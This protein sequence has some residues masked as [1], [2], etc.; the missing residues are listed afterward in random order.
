[1]WIAAIGIDRY[2]NQAWRLNN[3]VSDARGVLNAFE[4]LGF[5]E[6]ST[7][8][9]DQATN[10][11]LSCLVTD[12]LMTLNANDSL[13]VFFAGHGC[14][15]SR[16]PQDGPSMRRGYLLPVDAS[17][18]HVTWQRLDHWLSDIAHLPPRHI[19]VIL[20]S[21]H[22][23]VAL[24]HDTRWRGD[25]PKL[26][27]ADEPLRARRSRRVITSAQDNQSAIDD[28]PIRGHSLF[29]GC[30]I[31]ALLGGIAKRSREPFVTGA[32]LGDY[33][34]AEVSKRARHQ[35]TP[36]IG[37][38]EGDYGGQLFINLGKSVRRSQRSPTG[39]GA[40]PPSQSPASPS[41]DGPP[42][43]TWSPA[44]SGA[45]G[46]ALSVPPATASDAP[47]YP[48]P[49]RLAH[50]EHRATS[51]P[52]RTEGWTLD[53]ALAAALDR[54]GAERA[55]G[56]HVLSL[57]VGDAMVAQIAWATWAAGHG[58]LTLRTQA[59]SFH[60]AIADLL[61]QMP[62]LRC[63]T[64]ARKRLAAAARIDVQA[65]DAALD[66]R[67]A[68]E[69]RTWIEDVS[70][71]DRHAWVSGWLLS[72]LRRSAAGLP[73]LSTA[74]VQGS[75]LLAIAC[76]LACPTA[77]LIQHPAPD[78]S[79]LERAISIAAAL[80]AYLPGHSVAVT[81]PDTWIASV[82]HDGRQSAA[83]SMARQGL[84]AMTTPARRLPGRARRRTTK[85]LFD[86]LA[87]DPRTRGRFALDSEVS[88][89]EG[90]A[91]I[92]V[93]LVAL[94]AKIAVELDGWHHFHDPEGYWRDRIQD[95]RLQRAGYF[96]MRFLAEDVD[97]RL[98]STIDQIA[99]ALA[100][101]RASGAPSG[102]E[103]L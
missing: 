37:T 14:T 69:R 27:P 55:N 74:P 44:S 85:A 61:T 90:G 102:R 8:L 86:A 100:G 2:R 65:V 20:D 94:G 58:Y 25:A 88:I 7:L 36:A 84:V 29:T 16:G 101:R 79:W 81:A 32:Q 71:L 50:T 60:A 18:K 68:S 33:L 6:I 38:L 70:G 1:M 15:E 26:N 35:Q 78:A 39:S 30:L 21:C 4:R 49:V 72:A 52:E 42:P 64:E 54:H 89:P 17:Q 66:A 91:Q 9:D 22:S 67:S 11:A 62:W 59:D 98:V 45:G 19:L 53:I 73:E 75:E 56:C 77:V 24:D 97:E 31:D 13:V 47:P 43:S 40:P 87:L 5:Q 76:D 93:D 41:V 51:V 23:G 83:L 92:D 99:L 82:L 34:Q 63:L 103:I 3:A 96:V 80:I 10:E 48:Q 57:I 95:M 46:A 28:G 12:D